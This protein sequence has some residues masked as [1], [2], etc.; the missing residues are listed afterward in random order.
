MWA[1][2]TQC[3]QIVCGQLLAKIGTLDQYIMPHTIL[4]KHFKN[5]PLYYLTFPSLKSNGFGLVR[6]INLFIL[7]LE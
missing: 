6:L 2:V 5:E 3:S 4:L 1:Y 7:K